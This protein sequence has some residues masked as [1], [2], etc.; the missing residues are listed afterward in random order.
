MSVRFRSARYEILIEN[1]DSV[2]RGIVA[3]MIDGLAILERPLSLKLLDDGVTH[4][5]QVRLG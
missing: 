1:P 4:H 3:A 2:C 5:A